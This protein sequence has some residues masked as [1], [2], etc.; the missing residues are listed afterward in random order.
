MGTTLLVV[1]LA[2]ASIA[3]G[4][5]VAIALDQLAK[6]N[7]LTANVAGLNREN[8]SLK[9][10]VEDAEAHKAAEDI[11]ARELHHRIKN[12]FQTVSSLL[13]L[14]TRYLQDDV[15]KD[16][17]WEG[18]NRI[19]SMALIHQQLYQR[20]ST[21]EIEMAHYIDNL[22]NELAYSYSAESRGV[23]LHADVTPMRLPPSLA[24][25]LGLIIHELV[26]NSFKY[27]F[28]EG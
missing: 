13:N 3:A 6:V 16:I 25:P 19:K 1:G 7:R 9:A 27:A 17:L 4:V 18:Q 23:S 28:P 20:D 10:R 26:L 22:N 2:L 21:A 15:A 12:N 11:R 5:A 14:Q 8:E 24:I